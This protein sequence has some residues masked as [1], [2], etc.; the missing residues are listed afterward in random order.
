M[1]RRIGVA[2][3]AAALLLTLAGCGGGGSSGSGGGAASGTGSPAA[4]GGVG[5]GGGGT[6]SGA[7]AGAAV[8]SKWGLKPLPPAP[9]APA[10]RP[11][12]LSRTGPVP[13]FSRVPTTQ[14]VVFITIDDGL[15]KDPRFVEM[16]RELHVP[17]TM[18][19][20]NDAIKDDYGYFRSLQALGYSIQ[21]HTLHHPVMSRLGPAQQRNEICGD[22]KILTAEY[23]TA[24]YLFRPPY[25]A[26]DRATREAVRAC[27][28]AAIVY[29]TDTMEITGIRY[30][31]GRLRP[32]DII[33]AHF[34]GPQQLKGERM[35]AMF[36]NMVKR[37]EE[38]GFTVGRLDDYI[39]R[40]GQAG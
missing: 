13:G 18:F 32:G 26:Y 39:S 27:G 30:Q 15:V 9:A 23:G 29:W 36:A 40:P 34:R 38:Q 37:I 22:Q 25:G 7:A 8:W 10:D 12:K 19:L 4:A 6:G 31:N 2:A 20:M 33:L 11:I 1:H 17:I 14:R 28:P 24:P 3:G 16:E 21:N 35:T 5:G